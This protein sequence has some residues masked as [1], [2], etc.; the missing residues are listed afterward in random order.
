MAYSDTNSIIISAKKLVHYPLCPLSRFIRL[1]LSEKKAEYS[2]IDEP[3]W[4]RRDNLLTLNPSGTLPILIETDRRIIIRDV[5]PIFEYLNETLPPNDMILMPVNPT[6]R[7]EVRRLIHWFNVKFYTETSGALLNERV[8]KRQNRDGYP[9]S[10]VIRR[11][12]QSINEHILYMAYLL[13]NRDWLAGHKISAADLVAVAH[14][15]VID[16]LGNISW[17]P[18]N[19]TA[20]YALVRDWYARM[21]SRKSFRDISTDVVTGFTPP[22]H[23]ANPDF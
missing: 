15:S 1:I 5:Y 9:D 8:L 7:A 2:L 23:Y 19:H 10:G 3:Y 4:E 18:Q 6:E 14:I 13:N 22:L 21:K 20:E 11:A 17:T 12:L 16:F